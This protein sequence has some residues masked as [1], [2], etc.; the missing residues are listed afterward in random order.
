[1]FTL[2]IGDLYIP[3]RSSGIPQKFLKLLAPN[4]NAYPSNPKISQVV[5]LGNITQSKETLQYLYN[6][7]PSFHIVQGEF[8]DPSVISQQLEHIS[9][10]PSNLP[11]YKVITVDNFRIGFTNGHQIMPQ[12]DPLSLLA[13]AREINVDILI[14]GGTH[15]V[16]AY[17]LDGKY[18]INPGSASGAFHFGWPEIDD[19]E[20]EEDVDDDNDE[21]MTEEKVDEKTEKSSEGD[22]QDK[23][24]S[25][26]ELADKDENS[27]N[28]K[29]EENN[30]D[31]GK[32]NDP[33]PSFCLL[34][35]NGSRC[36]LY[37]YTYINNEVKVDKVIYQK[38]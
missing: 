30:E 29:K 24:E 13:F 15:R 4:S 2:A 8:D 20:E 27:S 35:T 19:I 38:D 26:E 6:I 12:N 14:W 1:M 11:Q 21:G 18:F 37:I 22:G 23:K 33:I 17:T 10:N 7:S 25:Q 9:G 28:S 5:C 34:E 16:E 36:T 31:D 32:L 3:D